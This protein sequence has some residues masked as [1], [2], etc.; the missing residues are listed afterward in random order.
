MSRPGAIVIG[1]GF[2]ARVHLPAMQAAG[3][4]VVA[5]VGRD[6]DKTARRAARL[7]VPAS[8][9]LGSLLASGE[10]AAVTI[11]TP[12]A[13]HA[14]L[15]VAAAEAGKHVLCE[16]PFA[17]DVAEAETMLAA[18]DAAGVTHL[19]GHEFRLAPER[20]VLGRA[21]AEGR[22][23]RVRLAT[24]VQ[25]VAL[26]ADP[27]ARTPDWWFDAGAGGGWLGASG[28]HVIDQVRAWLGDFE[29][30]SARLP[31]VSERTG[32]A[33]DT[34]VV[35]FR[36]RSGVDGVLA[37]TAAAWGPMTGV[38]RIV[39]TRASAWIDGSDAW[40]ADA[41]GTRRLDVPA[42][43]ALPSPPEEST[44]PRHRFTHLELG[45]FTRLGEA[46]LAG[47]EGRPVVSAVPL[48]TFADGVAAMR[49]LDAIRA[50]AAAGGAPVAC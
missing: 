22:L 6:P 24:L 39:G 16:K 13:T 7:G 28:S 18:A 31:V 17:L 4:D 15:A 19:I 37:Q 41:D 30:V 3:F 40:L 49:T 32:A 33:E 45:P 12:P 34:F 44:D 38:T 5:L 9:D 2:G 27:A 48:A 20:A 50:S 36:L 14:R 23:G 21:V 43:L 10:V 25:F 26:V 29:E 1:T 46:L 8:V 47:V 11:A 35:R 42:D